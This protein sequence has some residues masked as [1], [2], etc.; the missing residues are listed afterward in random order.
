[1]RI[2]SLVIFHTN[3]EL[4]VDLDRRFGVSNRQKRANRLI[5]RQSTKNRYNLSA[6]HPKYRRFSCDDRRVNHF[7]GDANGI[8][9]K[10]ELLDVENSLDY[11]LSELFSL[12]LTGD[13]H[14]EKV[15]KNRSISRASDSSNQCGPFRCADCGKEFILRRGLVQHL[16][17][18]H[19]MEE[20]IECDHCGKFFKHA[21]SL[22]RHRQLF[23]IESPVTSDTYVQQII[24]IFIEFY[25]ITENFNFQFEHLQK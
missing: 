8:E 21:H 3:F 1:M 16:R 19:T 5:S 12:I 6:C 23:S 13:E 17:M 25:Q 22:K 14:D 15:N 7:N 18:V 20:P 9:Y 11:K 2:M 4:G 24:N 10:H